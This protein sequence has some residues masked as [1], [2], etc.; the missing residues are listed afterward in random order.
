MPPDMKQKQP[1]KN[2]LKQQTRERLT[3]LFKNAGMT[4]E[5]HSA[6]A[7][8]YISVSIPSSGQNCAAVYGSRGG[9]ASL[10][11]KQDAWE[12]LRDEVNAA[13]IAESLRIEDVDLFRRGFQW[14]VHFN[15]PSDSHLEMA[16]NA[17]VESG[18]ERWRLTQERWAKEKA[19]LAKRHEKEKEIASRRRD[20]FA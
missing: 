5:N 10:W 12:L 13:G 1:S 19:A 20:P 3:T 2:A 11:M 7:V 17:C 18:K 14:A 6:G 16:V 8:N 9:A 4:I 15:S